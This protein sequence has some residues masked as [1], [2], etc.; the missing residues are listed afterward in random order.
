MFKHSYFKDKLSRLKQSIAMIVSHSNTYG[1]D[2]PVPFRKGWSG[3]L[4]LQQ[5]LK[6]LPFLKYFR[7]CLSH[8]RFCE[9]RGLRSGGLDRGTKS[10]L[11]RVHFGLSML[12][13]DL[14]SYFLPKLAEDCM[15]W[16][17][18]RFFCDRGELCW[19]HSRGSH[20]SPSQNRFVSDSNT[21]YARNPTTVIQ[22][23]MEHE[24]YWEEKCI[25]S[26][27]K[28]IN[29]DGQCIA[30]KGFSKL[31]SRDPRLD[32]NSGTVQPLERGRAR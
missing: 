25:G 7:K 8:F 1:A 28:F 18:P 14:L 5:S 3:Y 12:T 2:L 26:T 32:H 13:L 9:V 24:S 30:M 11:T 27:P 10:V 15:F 6:Y 29:V 19:A 16:A 21:L 22:A 17:L 31:A 20:F 4:C 23:T